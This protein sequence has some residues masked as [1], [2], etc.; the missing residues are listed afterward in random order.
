M[1]GHA[2]WRIIFIL[3]VG[4]SYFI[5]LFIYLFI[6]AL[7]QKATKYTEKIT[8]TDVKQEQTKGEGVT[9][10]ATG[11]SPNPPYDYNTLWT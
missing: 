4:I 5:Y 10:V 2:I 11:Q 3:I 9:G 8:T 6:V 1:V 7:P